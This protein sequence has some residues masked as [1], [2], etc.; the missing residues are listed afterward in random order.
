MTSEQRRS[1]LISSHTSVARNQKRNGFSASFANLH[2]YLR[3]LD[4]HAVYVTVSITKTFHAD[5]Q[6]PLSSH[7]QSNHMDL[8]NPKAAETSLV[9]ELSFSPSIK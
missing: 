2:S 8:L 9:T 6:L 3:G 7:L 5:L 4:S 1:A